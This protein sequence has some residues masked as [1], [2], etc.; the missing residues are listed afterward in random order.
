MPCGAHVTS[1]ATLDG[2]GRRKSRLLFLVLAPIHQTVFD[3]EQA[4]LTP[5]L[6]AYLHLAGA[7]FVFLPRVSASPT[8]AL[9]LYFAGRQQGGCQMM[10]WRCFERPSSI[11]AP[12]PSFCF[13]LTTMF[14]QRLRQWFVRQFNKQH[15]LSPQHLL[16]PMSSPGISL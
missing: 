1:K 13:L 16:G 8:W 6:K 10:P 9:M 11:S 15:V 2:A 4:K 3:G 7:P 5:P 12:F 14:P